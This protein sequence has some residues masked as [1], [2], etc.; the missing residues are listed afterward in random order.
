ME[1][2][3]SK[4]LGVEERVRMLQKDGLSENEIQ[5]ILKMEA[6]MVEMECKCI[7]AASKDLTVQ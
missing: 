2:L 5:V 3:T 4:I 6:V 7:N 1:E